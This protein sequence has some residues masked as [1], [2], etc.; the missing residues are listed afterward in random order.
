VNACRLQ[1]LLSSTD[2]RQHVTS[3]THE[4]GHTLDLVITFNDFTVDELTVD[5]P[6]AV[7]DHSLVSC[8][9]PLHRLTPPSFVRRV[10]AWSK[11]DGAALCQMIV[12]SPL[13][14]TPPSTAT[15]DE[16]FQMYNSSPC[17]IA[18][19]L[20]QER[21]V[22]FQLRPL[23]PWFDAECR[24]VRR[25]LRCLERRYR[26]THDA[27]DRATYITAS[28]DKYRL[29]NQK[30]TSYWSERIWTD[31]SSPAKLWRSLSALLQLIGGQLTPSCRHP[32]TLMIFC[33]SFDDK[34]GAVHA[35]TQGRQP[36]TPTSLPAEVSLSVLT[37]C[38]EDEVRRLIMGSPT[39]SCALNPI[40]TFFTKGGGRCAATICDLY[41]KH[42]IA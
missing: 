9:L 30:K 22:S 23:C 16:L 21:D 31:S 41:D 7:S 13:G 39:K 4:D 40:P 32:T 11:E 27:A 25:D 10:R 37:P 36:P 5:V 2:L 15:A 35:S 12:S 33:A 28:R 20:A 14:C 34:V 42:I 8:S 24:W 1:E 38:T 3:P 6:G 18:D 19:K 26:R 29:F 17:R